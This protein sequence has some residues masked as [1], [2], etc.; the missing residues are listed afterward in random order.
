MDGDVHIVDS[1]S[2]DPTVSRCETI[3]KIVNSL[4]TRRAAGDHSQQP[5]A[6]TQSRH[7]NASSLAL[8]VPAIM[9][10]DANFSTNPSIRVTTQLVQNPSP[11]ILLN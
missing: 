1:L 2:T 8:E 6:R 11:M 10:T 4:G 5:P 9:A 7:K 3:Q